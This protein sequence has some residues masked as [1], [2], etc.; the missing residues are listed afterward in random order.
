M[1]IDPVQLV[2]D[3]CTRTWV[4]LCCGSDICGGG[5][6]VVETRFRG[7]AEF[8]SDAHRRIVA[9]PTTGPIEIMYSGHEAEYQLRAAGR[10]PFQTGAGLPHFEYCG[11]PADSDTDQGYCVYHDRVVAGIE[12]PE[13]VIGDRIRDLDPDAHASLGTVTY[14]DNNGYWV[15]W[16]GQDGEV[17]ADFG[18]IEPLDD[19]WPADHRAHLSAGAGRDRDVGTPHEQPEITGLSAALAYT[20]AM[21]NGAAAGAASVEMSLTGLRSGEVGGQT[22]T[23]LRQAQEALSQAEA[24][25]QAANADLQ[26][27][28]SVKDAY[29][30]TPDAGSKQFVT[31]D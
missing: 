12:D 29:G 17:M 16:D 7:V 22:L 9:A 25:F 31:N 21:A 19:E 2:Y 11:F 30:A 1:G 23:H 24:A 8:H 18:D 26:T 4:V 13:I 27:H 28:L 3:S 6:E 5:H 14:A 10:C 20:A 15:Q